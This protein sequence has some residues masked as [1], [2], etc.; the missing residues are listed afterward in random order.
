M[1]CEIVTKQTAAT[2]KEQ[3]MLTESEIQIVK[4]ICLETLRSYETCDDVSAERV[5]SDVMDQFFEV[6]V[7]TEL[8]E[9]NHKD[10]LKQVEAICDPL[11]Y[12][13]RENLEARYA[14]AQENA[15]SLITEFFNSRGL[16]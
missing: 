15:H 3:K 14:C 7:S 2:V 6:F 9:K 12:D 8:W 4:N 13:Y 16:K 1:D 11:V 5:F 10:I